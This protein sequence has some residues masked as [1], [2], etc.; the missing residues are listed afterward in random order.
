MRY[1]GLTG[2]YLVAAA[3]LAAAGC[4]EPRATIRYATGGPAESVGYDSATFQ[5]IRDRKV[6]IILFRLAAAP[7]GEADP[8][9][10]YLFFELPE[11]AQYGWLRAD[12]VPAYRWVHK[13]GRN[14][15]WL[16][17]AGQVQ[18]RMRDAKQ[19]LSFDFRVTMEPVA[20]TPGAAYVLA[21]K[22]GVVE[23][24]VKTQSLINRYG[25]RLSAIVNPKPAEE[26]TK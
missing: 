1:V 24:P 15:V 25:E 21:G 22:P 18:L 14:Y 6:R 26:Q 23:D 13:S 11:R 19:H 12:R 3:A 8:D 20:G 4:G 16:G 17:F 7:V 10:E 2:V 5:L 9:F